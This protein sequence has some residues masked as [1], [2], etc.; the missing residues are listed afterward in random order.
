MLFSRIPAHKV[1]SKWVKFEFI[2][3]GSTQRREGLVCSIHPASRKLPRSVQ[4]TKEQINKI[5][6]ELLHSISRCQGDP[7]LVKNAPHTMKLVDEFCLQG[8]TPARLRTLNLA[9]ECYR[10]KASGIQRLPRECSGL[11]S[12]SL[13][14]DASLR[15]KSCI[16]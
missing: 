5:L 6:N 16:V 7:H 8:C 14:T 13:R 10:Q 1:D 11:A 9:T 15:S 2:S 3:T 12:A 4:I